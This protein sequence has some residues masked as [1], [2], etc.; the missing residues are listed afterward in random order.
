M[1]KGKD[2]LASELLRLLGGARILAAMAVN[3]TKERI[4]QIDFGCVAAR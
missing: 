3:V 2:K 1:P 4:I